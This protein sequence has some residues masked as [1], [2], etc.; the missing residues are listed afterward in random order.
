MNAKASQDAEPFLPGEAGTR[1]LATIHPSAVLRGDDREAL[2]Q[3]FLDDLK[4]AA[5]AV[6]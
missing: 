6:R 3:G 1:L 4:V 2:Y 5:S